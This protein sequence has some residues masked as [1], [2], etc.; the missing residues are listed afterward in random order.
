MIDGLLLARRTFSG[1]DEDPDFGTSSFLD[2]QLALFDQVDT[3]DT[4][5]VDKLFLD[6]IIEYRGRTLQLAGWAQHSPFAN[7][8]VQAGAAQS[9][10]YVV[11]QLC[12]LHN[13][14]TLLRSNNLLCSVPSSSSSSTGGGE[15][16]LPESS[17][18]GEIAESNVNP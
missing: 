5:A 4:Y 18:T 9:F 2:T 3:N 14:L 11:S 15:T 8:D 16:L 1:S 12:V 6:F 10:E 7:A 13:S 17:S